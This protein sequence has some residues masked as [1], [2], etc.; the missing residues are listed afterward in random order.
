MNPTNYCLLIIVCFPYVFEI[1]E[2]IDLELSTDTPTADIQLDVSLSNENGQITTSGIPVVLET[3]SADPQ[4][5][6]ID[7]HQLLHT[8]VPAGIYFRISQKVHLQHSNIACIS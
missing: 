8:G 3:E 1:G 5:K 4:L 2:S 7:Q 6:D